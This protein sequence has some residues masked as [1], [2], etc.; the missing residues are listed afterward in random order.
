[1]NIQHTSP[2]RNKSAW[3][4]AKAAAR[5]PEAPKPDVKPEKRK[6]SPLAKAI[7]PLVEAD[8]LPFLR[9]A[10][11]PGVTVLYKDGPKISDGK[12]PNLYD[13][14]QWTGWKGWPDY[15]PTKDDQI[16]WSS[17][18]GAGLALVTGEVTAFDVDIKVADADESELARR[19]RSLIG[20]IGTM[21]ARFSGVSSIND[22]PV[23]TRSGSSSC[24]ILVRASE[25]FKKKKVYI[26]D[27]S[28]G[29]EFA[30]ER[31]AAGQQVI[32]AGQHASGHP[33]SCSL[34]NFPFAELPTISTKTAHEI[35]IAIRDEAEK[36]GFEATLDATK[37]GKLHQ[38]RTGP[39]KPAE[40]VKHAIMKRRAEWL[41]YI[42]P[43][44]IGASDAEWSIPSRDDRFG[45]DRDLQERLCIY[46]D[47]IYDFGTE[48]SHNPVSLIC[49]FGS[50]DEA[51]DISFGGCPEYGPDEDIPFAVVSDIEGVRR[52]TEAQAAT[53]LCRQLGDPQMKV[54]PANTTLIGAMP[55]L[56]RAVGL[57]WNA[58]GDEEAA[59]HFEGDAEN[60]DTD[61]DTDTDEAQRKRPLITIRAGDLASL[62]TEAEAALVSAGADLYTRAGAI[63][64]P[65]VED[66][67]A[68]K[69]RTATV[70]RTVKVSKESLTDYLAR[71]ADW[72]KFDKRSNSMVK[73]DPTKQIAEI[74]LSRDGEWKLPKLS[75]VVTTPTLRP[76]LSMLSEPG[77]D[78]ATGLLLCRPP[79]M[80]G[81]PLAPTRAQAQEALALLESLIS[82]FTFVSDA[83]KSVALSMLM[84]PVVRGAMACAPLHA[85]RAPTPGSGKSYLTD[86]AAAIST[87][88]PCPVI[89]PHAEEKELE[90]RLGAALLY[91]QSLVSI[92]NLNGALSGDALCQMVDRPL[93]QVR[94]LGVSELV[95]IEN[96]HTVFATGNNLHLVGDIVRRTIVC[97]IDTGLER[98]E[99]RRFGSNPFDAILADR[100]KYV[101]AVIT[102]VRAYQAAGF[103]S[104]Q[105]GPASFGDWAKIVRSPL[106]WLGCADPVATMETARAEDPVLSALSAVM[107]AWRD[108]IGLDKP[109]S[110]GDLKACA[111]LPAHPELHAALLSVAGD[112]STISP[113][114]LGHWL[115]KYKGRIVGGLKFEDQMDRHAKQKV[116]V[117]KPAGDAGVCGYLYDLTR[118]T[119]RLERPD[120]ET[121]DTSI[122]Q[123]VETPANTRIT[124]KDI[125]SEP[126]GVFA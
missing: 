97:T 67:P 80:P 95:R 82:G 66:L 105:E 21:I 29:A 30:V 90:K 23:R 77:Y 73:A 40:K 84:T 51:G 39:L 121:P 13:G 43:C 52:P 87:G 104:Q 83:D 102:I 65:V 1:M 41:P 33:I 110:A 26:K 64:R 124:R 37:A 46:P 107:N 100:G 63:V 24:A 68:A 54:L 115:A 56:A 3:E 122:E 57:D 118:R 12:I 108:S 55:A 106:I 92:D 36:H 96:K 4:T 88:Q 6:L 89:T 123:M 103:P 20:A 94:P 91:G 93:V 109:L 22:L 19:A 58:L 78:A 15:K 86:L 69:D 59:R 120:A 119:V 34:A 27:R 16:R 60:S 70:P 35:L 71:A 74:I 114:R 11:P 44:Q 48:R 111:D 31:L 18:E 72:Q 32:I 50:I 75:G 116:W 10:S 7:D 61:T 14:N 117:L 28:S 45:L 81:I 99:N 53:W 47:G 79:K 85:V 101:A 76:D 125:M 8:Y 112:R 126:I 62:A 17:W 49:E 98:P 113:L 5:A 2:D 42:V 25:K 38:Q 9:P